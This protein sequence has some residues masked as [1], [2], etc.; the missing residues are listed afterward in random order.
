MKIVNGII[1]HCHLHFVA[2]SRSHY[3]DR[4]SAKLFLNRSEIELKIANANIV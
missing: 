1:N 3:I 2:I 4:L